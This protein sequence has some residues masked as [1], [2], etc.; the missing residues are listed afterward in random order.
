MNSKESIA[1]KIALSVQKSGGRA[2]YVGGYVRDKLMN[3]DVD[4]TPDIDIEVHNISQDQLEVLLSEIVETINVGKSFGII[5]LADY[6]IDIALPRRERS[7]GSKHR[8]FDVLVDE[9]IGTYT[10]AKRRDFTINSIMEDILTGELI[11]HFDGI[12]DIKKG[13]IRHI[14][15]STFIED[16]L[17]VLRAARFASTLQFAIDTN[18]LELCKT[19]DL[20]T[21][22]KERIFDEV[23]KVFLKSKKPSV[24]FD[25]LYSMNHLTYWFTEIEELKG[26]KQSSIYHAEGDVYTHTMMVLDEGAHYLSKVKEPVNYMFALLCHDLGKMITTEEVNGRIRSL[27]HELEGVHVAKQF[28]SRLTNNKRL[29]HYVENMV[30]HHMMPNMYALSHSKLKVTNRMFYHSVEPNDL[31][32]IA[33]ADNKGRIST[34]PTMSSE[35]FLFD[36]LKQYHEIMKKPHVTGRDLIEHGLPENPHF[37]EIMAH[38]TKLRLA[39]V[40]KEEALKQTL[41]FARTLLKNK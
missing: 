16:P 4:A 30:K 26:I 9:H 19:M 31:I 29:I 33:L 13:I 5:K 6:D 25:E 17:R 34:K 12:S 11:D 27:K 3:R 36:R 24:F 32:Y 41:G 14:D 22:S 21:L 15:D 28:L 18:T 40:D 37:S 39:G 23:V 38:A 1:K 7:T 35:D 20:R 2:F 8:D 10:A